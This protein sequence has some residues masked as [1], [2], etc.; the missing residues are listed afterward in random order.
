MH[1]KKSDALAI[2]GNGIYKLKSTNQLI[3]YCEECKAHRWQE[4]NAHI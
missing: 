3:N 1:N 2:K 4:E